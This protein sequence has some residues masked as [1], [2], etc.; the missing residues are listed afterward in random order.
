MAQSEND[1]AT[2]DVQDNAAQMKGFPLFYKAPEILDPTRHKGLGLNQ[3]TSFSFA[4]ATNAIP[5]N[6]VEFSLASRDYPIVFIGEQEMS[7]VAIVGLRKD[8]NVMVDGSGQWAAGTYV[9]AYVR[10][11]PFVFV[12]DESGTQYALCIDRISEKIDAN[13]ENVFFDGNELT[14]LSKNAMQFCTVFQRHYLASETIFKQ[15]REFDLFISHQGRFSLPGG[16]ILSLKDFK[17]IDEKRFN[18]L[19][20]E[21][22]AS[23]WKSGA[24]AAVYCHLISMNS[25]QSL[26]SR[27]PASS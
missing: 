16:E 1:V 3:S 26:V 13:T 11:Y 27:T 12:R 15:L 23:L 14:E 5:I 22:V 7:S 25:W 21:A 19:S 9:P 24:L 2:E 18:A 17:I 6:A 4:A 20:E 8:E 10:R